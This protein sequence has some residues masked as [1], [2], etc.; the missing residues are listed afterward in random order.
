MPPTGENLRVPK[1]DMERYMSFVGN[2]SAHERRR[3]T[4]DWA[5]DAL[6]KT[7]NDRLELWEALKELEDL[8]RKMIDVSQLQRDP[9]FNRKQ[10]MSMPFEIPEYAEYDEWLC[11]DEADN[12]EPAPVVQAIPPPAGGSKTSQ[13]SENKAP[14]PHHSSNSISSVSPVYSKKVLHENVS[15]PSWQKMFSTELLSTDLFLLRQMDNPSGGGYFDCLSSDEIDRV[16]A[17]LI[18]QEYI[19]ALEFFMV[20]TG[21]KLAAPLRERILK[22]LKAGRR[23]FAPVHVRFHWTL[24]VFDMIDAEVIVHVFDSAPSEV[25]RGD[26]VALLRHCGFDEPFFVPC[27]KQPR[28]SVE[29]GIHVVLNAWRVFLE[30]EPLAPG[31]VLSLGHLRAACAQLAAK[32]PTD[33]ATIRKI[34]ANPEEGRPGPT[35]GAATD[36]YDD[37]AAI[38]NSGHSRVILKFRVRDDDRVYE[39][40]GTLRMVARAVR[41]FTVDMDAGGGP[42][43]AQS[44][45]ACRD[46][47]VFF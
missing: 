9:R 41:N 11:D 35:G 45:Q 2:L 29:C 13:A 23:V 46:A 14:K 8:H 4:I 15:A 16:V 1:V 33:V 6:Y 44:M 37:L 36:A 7:R 17:P 5:V 3:D 22:S 24:A 47:S 40:S 31:R 32:N 18:G 34:A 42:P 21:R 26:I 12:D 38:R 39:A 43:P 27:G 19:S 30:L 20:R 28:D 10:W 25:T